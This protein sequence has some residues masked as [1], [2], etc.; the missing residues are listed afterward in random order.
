MVAILK[1]IAWL[2]TERTLNRGS[3]PLLLPKSGIVK[4][5]GPPM[6]CAVC[7]NM[8]KRIMDRWQRGLM[9]PPAKR[10]MSCVRITPDPPS[11]RMHSANIIILTFNQKKTHPVSF[12][13]A[14]AEG[15]LLAL[16]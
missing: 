10:K 9:R 7:S 13:A 8:V 1:H 12:K 5:Y 15:V 4:I 16:A 6:C 11:L 2:V 3:E 14:V